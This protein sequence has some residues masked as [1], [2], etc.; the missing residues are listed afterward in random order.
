MTR[1]QQQQQLKKQAGLRCS[2]GLLWLLC[3]FRIH[4]DKH[5]IHNARGGGGGRRRLT[6]PKFIDQRDSSP[7]VVQCPLNIIK[8]SMNDRTVQLFIDL[9]EVFTNLQPKYLYVRLLIR[10]KLLPVLVSECHNGLCRTRS[11]GEIE[12]N[13]TLIRVERKIQVSIQ[14]HHAE[15]IIFIP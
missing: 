13:D 2:A 5:L 3:F 8:F 4:V 7:P 12:K 14:C 6:H 15:E 11:S 1:E 10:N 9:E